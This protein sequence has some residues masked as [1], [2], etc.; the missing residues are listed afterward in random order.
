MKPCNAPSTVGVP[1]DR[2]CCDGYSSSLGLYSTTLRATT[3]ALVCTNTLALPPTASKPSTKCEIGSESSTGS[4]CATPSAS[5]TVSV[6]SKYPDGAF[7]FGQLAD[8]LF[9]GLVCGHFHSLRHFFSHCLFAH[10]Y[11]FLL[12]AV[13]QPIDYRMN[14]SELFQL[15]ESVHIV[16]LL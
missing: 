4:T 5:V 2:A 1:P 13:L 16:A 6:S 11:L 9:G 14:V 15:P 3:P 12:S 10:D 7:E 8:F